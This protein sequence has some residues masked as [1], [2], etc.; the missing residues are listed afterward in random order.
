VKDYPDDK[1]PD[2]EKKILIGEIWSSPIVFRRASKEHT[3][4]GDAGA[5]QKEA[6]RR[7]LLAREKNCAG[8]ER[9]GR[10]ASVA[11]TI[12]LALMSRRPDPCAIYAQSQF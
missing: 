9:A 12:A 4:C 11:S 7:V 5:F 10:K 1:K 8:I 3:L 2:N 6:I